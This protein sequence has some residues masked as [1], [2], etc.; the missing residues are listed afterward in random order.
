MSKEFD[1]KES[2][3]LR[4]ILE[5]GFYVRL[6]DWIRDNESPEDVFNEDQLDTWATNNGYEKPGEFRHH[7]WNVKK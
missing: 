3:L 4:T 2:D 1:K 5:S 7:S 6:I